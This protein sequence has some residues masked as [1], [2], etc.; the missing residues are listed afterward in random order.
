MAFRR[1][2][3]QLVAITLRLDHLSPAAAA[4]RCS[5]SSS[6]SSEKSA[7]WKA[8]SGEKRRCSPGLASRSILNMGSPYLIRDG[9][10]RRSVALSGTQRRSVALSGASYPSSNTAMSSPGALCTLE[11]IVSMARAPY[12]WGGVRAPW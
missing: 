12:L 5:S 3:R 10:Q 9:N 7:K 11:T 4:V 1:N 8:D 2:Q 6:C